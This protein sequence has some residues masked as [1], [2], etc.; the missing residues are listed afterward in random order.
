MHGGPH[1]IYA[2]IKCYRNIGLR[3]DQLGG[4]ARSLTPPRH[5]DSHS[6]RPGSVMAFTRGHRESSRPFPVPEATAPR[7]ETRV[8]ATDPDLFRHTGTPHHAL[9]PPP[10]TCACSTGHRDLT[11]SQA[12]LP[13]IC[14]SPRRRPQ[15]ATYADAQHTRVP[16]Y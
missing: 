14:P 7:E 8:S 1:V 12:V 16:L 6:G 5:I 11:R 2:C 3:P 4:G 9:G 13:G 10:S 15:I